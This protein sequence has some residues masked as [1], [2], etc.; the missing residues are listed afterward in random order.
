MRGLQQQGRANEAL[1]DE[2][3]ALGERI[4]AMGAQL[5]AQG[6]AMERLQAEV[7]AVLWL[8]ASP[9]ACC[10]CWPETYSVVVARQ[11]H[12]RNMCMCVL[13]AG[14]RRGGS[15]GGPVRGARRA[16]GGS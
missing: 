12:R 8:A 14:W 6:A 10:V 13:L 16:Q 2:N 15:G 3:K 4:N 7:R 5:E 9:P 11:T 1:A